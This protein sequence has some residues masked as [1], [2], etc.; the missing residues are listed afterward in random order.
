M[1]KRSG[2]VHCSRAGSCRRQAR[3]TKVVA[4]W[5]CTVCRLFPPRCSDGDVLDVVG[6]CE[7]E[8]EEWAES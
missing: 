4:R 7:L 2:P 1:E 5:G 8:S 3:P 6:L